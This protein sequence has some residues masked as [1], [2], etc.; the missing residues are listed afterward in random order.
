[1]ERLSLSADLRYESA[2]F[3]DDLNSRKLSAGTEI[4]ARAGW[5]VSNG[6]EVYV[7]IDN[8]ADENLETGQ[9]A[10]GVLSLAAPRTVRVGFSLRR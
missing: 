2:R 7:A 8:V 4:D 5:R 10:D 6:A 3:E 1:M 9:T